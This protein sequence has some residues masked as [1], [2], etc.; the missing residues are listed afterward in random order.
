MKSNLI[1]IGNSKGVR[2][3]SSIIKECEL[4]NE[5]EI[6]VV[7]KKIII[8]ALKEPRSNWAGSFEKMHKNKEDILIA[9]SSNSFDKDW[10]W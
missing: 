6:K 2:I 4:G 5:I 3:T 7:D 8:E 10:E 1:K 9:E